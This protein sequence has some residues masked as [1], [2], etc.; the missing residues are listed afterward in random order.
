MDDQDRTRSGEL[1][2]EEWQLGVLSCVLVL[3][4]DRLSA[5][6]LRR[7]IFVDDQDFSQTDAFDRAVRDLV[8]V[9]LLRHDGDSVIATRAASYFARLRW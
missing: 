4:P 7:Q 1:S 9:G 6:E 3:H 8:A 5:A 2:D